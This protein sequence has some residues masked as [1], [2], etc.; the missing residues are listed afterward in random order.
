MSG[1]VDLHVHTTAS[2]G[3]FSPAEI[4]HQALEIGLEAIAITDHDTVDG[5]AQA[6]EAANS[7]PLEVIPGV[8]LSAVNSKIEVHVLGYYIDEN[9]QG[10]RDTLTRLRDSRLQRA[11][12]MLTRLARM[13]MPL[14]WNE[15]QR[16]A[17]QAVIGRPHISLAMLEH[18]YVST[19][20]EAFNLYIG[21]GRPAYAERYKLL[22]ADA[23]RTIVKAGGIPV[24]AHPLEV[25]GLVPALVGSGLIGL[26][27]HYPGYAP[28]ETEFLLRLAKKHGLIATGGSDFHGA[29]ILPGHDL[30][31]VAVP[32]QAVEQLR[33]R[34]RGCHGAA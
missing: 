1:R 14:D 29:D 26:E 2:D 20:A 16:S 9:D 11:Q 15:L 28:D 22:P 33:T 13:G 12:H 19:V 10:L 32:Y 5:V 18:G 3:Q 31:S 6:L 21:R 4:V 24:L 25:V 30:G 17:G 8:E 7:T 27:A 34:R 23:V